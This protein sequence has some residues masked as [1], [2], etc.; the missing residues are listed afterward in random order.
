[1]FS[2]SNF[3]Q[4]HSQFLNST[5]L[6]YRS[7]LPDPSAGVYEAQISATRKKETKRRLAREQRDSLLTEVL[8]MEVMMG[9]EHG[10]RWQPLD[11]QYIQ[12]AQ[13]MSTRKYHQ[14][15]D[16]LQ[17]LVVLRLFEL[18]KLNLSQTGMLH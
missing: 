18:H 3:N 17:R 15:L 13:Y 5:Q 2:R 10:K 6:D 8:S 7:T 1:M 12:T 16:N 11:E 14:A 4:S 9:I